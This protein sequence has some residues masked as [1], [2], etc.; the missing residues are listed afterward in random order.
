MTWLSGWDSMEELRLTRCRMLWV[1][2]IGCLL[3]NL[4]PVFEAVSAVVTP[5]A[6][7]Y[8]QMFGSQPNMVQKILLQLGSTVVGVFKKFATVQS[9]AAILSLFTV[10]WHED[11]YVT[12]FIPG[13]AFLAIMSVYILAPCSVLDPKITCCFSV[14]VA[15][16]FFIILIPYIFGYAWYNTNFLWNTA[17]AEK[18]SGITY[19]LV[20][21]HGNAEYLKNKDV[22]EVQWMEGPDNM[23]IGKQVVDWVFGAHTADLVIQFVWGIFEAVAL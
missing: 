16:L 17:V 19:G 11:F 13:K 23:A 12:S 10:Y 22:L 3:E 15:I 5:Q 18:V 21:A 4:A 7:G 14:Y 20:Q 9:Q 6:N 8:E 1:L 2:A